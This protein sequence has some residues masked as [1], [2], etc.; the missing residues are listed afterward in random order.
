MFWGRAA[1]EHSLPCPVMPAVRP[2]LRPGG[3]SDTQAAAP[4][5]PTGGPM[6]SSAPT[7]GTAALHDRHPPAM[8]DAPGSAVR[9]PYIVGRAFTPAGEGSWRPGRVLARQGTAPL[10]RL[11]RQ[12]PL[13]GSLLGGSF[14]KASPVRGCGVERRLR[15][16]KRDGAGLTV[17]EHKRASARAVRCGHRKPDGGC[18]VRRR[19]RGAL[20]LC[21]TGILQN[22][23]GPCPR[24]RRGRCL[25]RPG[26]LA[27]PQT[28]GGGRNRPPY[29]AAGRGEQHISAGLP[30]DPPAGRCKH[31]PETPCNTA[32]KRRLPARCNSG[33]MQSIGPLPV[34]R[35]VT[36]GRA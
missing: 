23:A 18:A 32:P 19:R 12:L 22:P 9:L 29:I 35:S 36:T 28:P 26:N 20:P 4:A 27:M 31:R 1:R 2:A 5:R 8:P 13:Q 21:P 10:S 33:P 17:A 24:I 34:Q 11:C 30:P 15:R 3:G 25:H 7:Q 6:K 16:R 14:S